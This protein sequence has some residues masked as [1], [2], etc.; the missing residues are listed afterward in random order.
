MG[1]LPKAIAH[2][3]DAIHLKP[4]DLDAHY[5]LGDALATAGKVPEAI[6]GVPEEV[7][8]LDPDDDEAHSDLGT[9]PHEGWPHTGCRRSV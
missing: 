6:S 4:D 1:R 2:Y 3:E 7:L 5:D 9:R 8:R